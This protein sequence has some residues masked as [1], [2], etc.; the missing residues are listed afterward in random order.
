VGGDDPGG[1]PSSELRNLRRRRGVETG[2]RF[3]TPDAD[4]VHSGLR[5]SGVDA[6]D[7][8]RWDGV[9]PMFAFRDLDGNGMEIVEQR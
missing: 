8:L 7:V 9:P 6:D 4:E 3:V 5:A 2:I 1:V